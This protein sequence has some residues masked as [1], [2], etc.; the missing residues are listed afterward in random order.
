LKTHCWRGH[1]FSV[2]NT[3]W[4]RKKDGTAYRECRRCENLRYN[5]SY[6]R[7]KEQQRDD[8]QNKDV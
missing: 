1:R 7:K 5:A 6:K 3:R 8:Q 4:H 2:A